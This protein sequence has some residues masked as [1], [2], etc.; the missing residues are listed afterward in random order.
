M[1]DDQLNNFDTLQSFLPWTSVRK[2]IKRRENRAFIS[3]S[4][5]EV[6]DSNNIWISNLGKKNMW[7]W[8]LKTTSWA[9]R[10]YFFL[11][12][13]KDIYTLMPLHIVIM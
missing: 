4:I 10:G 9:N 2:D 7:N 3:L 1:W 8:T 6:L 13:Q 11:T 5:I 12:F